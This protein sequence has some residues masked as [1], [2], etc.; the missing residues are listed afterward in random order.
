ML[1][2]A[3]PGSYPNCAGNFSG[4]TILRAKRFHQPLAHW[5][6]MCSGSTIWS[7]EI[8][9]HIPRFRI[10]RMVA[11]RRK[12]HQ[13]SV[14]YTL[15]PRS[16]VKLFK[17]GGKGECKGNCSY[18]NNGLA[19]TPLCKCYA[20]GCSKHKDYHGND[21][22]EDMEEEDLDWYSSAKSLVS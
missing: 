22:E 11:G 10:L 1:R 2:N 4:Q 20:A 18:A 13:S 6:H 8:G 14:S 16:L 21:K 9:V 17:C 3:Q 15:Q 12:G 19:C 5:F 7:C